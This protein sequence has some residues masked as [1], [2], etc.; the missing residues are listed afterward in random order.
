MSSKRDYIAVA[1]VIKA[2][3]DELADPE[4]PTYFANGEAYE[5]LAKVGEGLAT[6]FEH[7][8]AFDRGRFLKACGL[9]DA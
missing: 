1:K 6:H 4:V 5:T 7:N 3:V 8:P 9:E 2:Q